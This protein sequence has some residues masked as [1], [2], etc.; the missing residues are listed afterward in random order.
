MRTYTV[1]F[2][3][4]AKKLKTTV[5]ANDKNDAQAQVLAKINFI[6]FEEANPFGG[7]IEGAI[8]AINNILFPKK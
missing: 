4:G 5:K 1:Y 8:D 2:E 7:D 3:I 6:K